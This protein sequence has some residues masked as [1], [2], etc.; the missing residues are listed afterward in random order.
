MRQEITQGFQVQI[1]D[2]IQFDYSL[3]CLWEQSQIESIVEKINADGRMQ[4]ISYNVD[5]K[6]SWYSD[7]VSF[8]VKVL[9]NPFPVLI[10]VMAIGAIATSLFVYL[11]LNKIFLISREVPQAV[12]GIT[13][14]VSLGLIAVIAIAI[15]YGLKMFRT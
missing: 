4:V 8:Q 11:S 9:Q 5:V 10:L 1:G 3:V 13:S 6:N 7:L 2:V 15:I 14:T 12:T